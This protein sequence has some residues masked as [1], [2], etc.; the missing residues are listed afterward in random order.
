MSFSAKNKV[1]FHEVIAG[2]PDTIST[3]PDYACTAIVSTQT[4]G[5]IAK[6]QT[7][8]TITTDDF[9]S[10]FLTFL[11]AAIG[12][13]QPTEADTR[14]YEDGTESTAGPGSSAGTGKRYVMVRYG[15]VMTDAFIHTGVA[16]CYVT[17]ASWAHTTQ[18]EEVIE[19]ALEIK[20][21]VQGAGNDIALAVGLW[22]SAILETS[23]PS[24]ALPTTLTGGTRGDDYHCQ[25]A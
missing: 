16:N 15:G 24:P 1:T 4:D 17:D 23:G 18:Y 21:L 2:S 6:K 9:S 22:D 11:K 3:T 13:T 5:L 19:P 8:W 10:T 12:T 14:Y 7:T 25:A 20:T